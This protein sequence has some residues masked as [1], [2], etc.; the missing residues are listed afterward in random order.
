M[1]HGINANVV[2]SCRQPTRKGGVTSRHASSEFVAVAQPPQAAAV[3]GGDIQ[4]LLARG[5]TTMT[6]VWQVS[7][8]EGFAV[9]MRELLTVAPS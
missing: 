4:I 8:A 5:E 9:R 7:A 3:P 1:A 2:H 6:L